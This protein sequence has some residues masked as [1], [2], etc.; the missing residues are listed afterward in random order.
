MK[1]AMITAV[2]LMNACAI[3]EEKDRFIMMHNEQF[4]PPYA[5][6]PEEWRTY[7]ESRQSFEC[8]ELDDDTMVCYRLLRKPVNDIN[9]SSP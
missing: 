5:V 6:S 3:H 2:F 9:R 1:K 4:S 7:E 8:F